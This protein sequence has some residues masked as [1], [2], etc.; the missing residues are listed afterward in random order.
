MNP[1]RRNSLGAGLA[2]ATGIASLRGA[3]AQGAAYPSRA[4][5]VLVPFP[6]AIA[7]RGITQRARPGL[8][9]RHDVVQRPE[10]RIRCHDQHCRCTDKSGDR[11]KVLQR[12]IGYSGEQAGVGDKAA[13]STEQRIAIGRCTRRLLGPNIATSPGPVF[14]HHRLAITG[15]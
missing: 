3:L 2:L 1:L 12:V 14:N 11:R 13:G 4:I 5:R 7:T 10:R 8:G 15:R 9:A 6:P